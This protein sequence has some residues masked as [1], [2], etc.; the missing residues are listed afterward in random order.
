MAKVCDKVV[1]VEVRTP[2]WFTFCGKIRHSTLIANTYN[3][4]CQS[5]YLLYQLFCRGILY[6]IC[7]ISFSVT[8]SFIIFAA[9]VI[10]PW[11]PLPYLMYQLSAI[12]SF[13]IFAVS[14][15]LLWHPLSYLLYWLFYYASYFAISLPPAVTGPLTTVQFSALCVSSSTPL[16]G[17]AYTQIGLQHGFA[18][19]LGHP[20]LP[21]PQLNKLEHSRTSP[22][23]LTQIGIHKDH[24]CPSPPGK[25]THARRVRC[26]LQIL[27]RL[28]I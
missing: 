13:I 19:V 25:E 10:L 21:N 8:A 12:A 14:V 23:L 17:L 3:F 1:Q 2:S 15:G 26:V 27:M 28:L 22:G 20:R 16:E 7:C 9:L 5:L 18:K 4:T 11:H 24:G 6:H